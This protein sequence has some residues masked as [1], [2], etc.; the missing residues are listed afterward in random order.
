MSRQMLAH[1]PAALVAAVS[2]ACG[3]AQSA[4]AVLIAVAV[5]PKTPAVQTT[6]AVTFVASVSGTPDT[7]V[8]WSVQEGAAG[9]TVAVNGSSAVYTAPAQPGSYHVIATSVADATKT[10]VASVT[11]TQGAPPRVAL[12]PKRIAAVTNQTIQFSTTVTGLA[13]T[14]VTWSVQ[15]GSPGGTISASGLYTAPSTAGTFHVV[16]TSHANTSLSD[17]G[18]VTVT[19]P[20]S[21]TA[22]VWQNVTPAG[23]NIAGSGDNFGVQDVLVDPARPSD[24]YVF[25]TRQ[26]VWKSTDAGA[27]WAKIS[28]NGGPMD[29]GKPWGEAIDPNPGRNPAVP[30][31]MYGTQGNSTDQGILKS[32]DGGA[33]W[34]QVY[35][36]PGGYGRDVYDLDIDPND[37]QHLIATFHDSSKIVESKDGGKTWLGRGA[38]GGATMSSYVFFVTSNIWLMVSQWTDSNGT[39]RTEDSGTTWSKVSGNE[40]F[41]GNCQIYLGPA[42]VVYLPGAHGIERSADYGKTWTSVF[43]PPENSVVATAS[44]LYA[45]DGWATQGTWDANLVRSPVASGTTW[46]SYT[47][48]PANMTNGAKRAAVAFDGTHYVIVSGNWNAG[49]WRYV[50]N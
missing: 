46:S 19:G 9:G 31:T 37:S 38:V 16:A 50:E 1:A 10:D 21:G 3:P 18:V 39:W 36:D 41:H 42:G 13:D 27:T 30:P 47:T 20:A 7:Q 40:H 48:K 6:G 24:V 44:F 34:T 14:S 45:S 11:V 25:I 26:G 8:S 28:A 33:T 17:Q 22:G 4:S 2:I 35:K 29:Q 32:G 49:L 15:E 5:D 23:V 12:A 43:G